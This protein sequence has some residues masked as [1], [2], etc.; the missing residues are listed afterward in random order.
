VDHTAQRHRP[1]PLSKI[2][3]A[4]SYDVL[5][6]LLELCVHWL[7]PGNTGATPGHCETSAARIPAQDWTTRQDTGAH[8]TDCTDERPTP[9]DKART[10]APQPGDSRRLNP[11]DRKVV[12]VRIPPPAHKPPVQAKREFKDASRPAGCGRGLVVRRR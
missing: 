12:L 3:P 6:G 10:A 1:A 9:K 2:A 4:A 7:S 8:W 5:R 11:S